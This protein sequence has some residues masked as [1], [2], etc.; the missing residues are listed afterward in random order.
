M[1]AT[2]N[3]SNWVFSLVFFSSVIIRRRI[4]QPVTLNPIC[5]RFNVLPNVLEWNCDLGQCECETYRTFSY[6]QKLDVMYEPMNF[7]SNELSLNAIHIWRTYF[8]SIVVDLFHWRHSPHRTTHLFLAQNIHLNEV[9]VGTNRRSSTS[10]QNRDT[11][12]RHVMILD[13]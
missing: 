13:S 1:W 9:E 2:N 4:W 6:R 11:S 3:E 10:R 7:D 8:Q 5:Y 12:R